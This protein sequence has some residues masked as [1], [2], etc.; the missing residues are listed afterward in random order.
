MRKREPE[1]ILIS[2]MDGVADMLMYF[3]AITL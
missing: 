1:Q 3:L 2:R